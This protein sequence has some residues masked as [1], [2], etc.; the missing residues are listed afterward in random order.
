MERIK[1]VKNNESLKDALKIRHKVFI[2][3]Q[4]I[5]KELEYDGMDKKAEHVIIYENNN[6]I[7]TGRVFKMEEEFMLGRICVLKEFRGK[8]FGNIIVK[9]LVNRALN[10]GANKIYIHAQA[11]LK[12]FYINLGF[13]PVGEIFE[14]AGIEHITMVY[15][16]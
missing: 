3:E 10:K 15:E 8:N 11:Y 4:K 1:W 13:T 12:E 14:E 2:E 9:L 6:P 5:S 7:A 16:K